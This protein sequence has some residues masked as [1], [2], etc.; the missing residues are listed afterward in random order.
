MLSVLAM[1]SEWVHHVAPGLR[2]L[3]TRRVHQLLWA[4]RE[5][6]CG[7]PHRAHATVENT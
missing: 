4:A 3:D 1:H 7:D 5:H 2:P 6:L